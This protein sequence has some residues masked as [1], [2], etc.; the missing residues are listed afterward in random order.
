MGQGQ[1]YVLP[2]GYNNIVI[3][4]FKILLLDMAFDYLDNI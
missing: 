1:N 4:L 3:Y 2:C